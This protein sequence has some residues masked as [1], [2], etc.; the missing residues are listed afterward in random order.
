MK[1]NGTTEKVLILGT[2]P[3]AWKIAEVMGSFTFRY[4]IVGF[5][6]DDYNCG[7]VVP[8]NSAVLL[9]NGGVLPHNGEALPHNG[10]T[11]QGNGDG[12]YFP[13]SAFPIVGPID[14]LE[15][16]IKDLR[17]DRIIVPIT[18]DGLLPVQALLNSRIEG[19]VVE[20]GDEVYERLTQKLAI[21]SLPPNL[22]I[23]SKD[24]RKPL[25]QMVLRRATSLAFAAI[26]LLLT[27]PLMAII[28]LAIK[29]ESR[30]PIFFFQEREGLRGQKFSLIKFRTMNPSSTEETGWS[31]EISSRVTRV[32]KWLRKYRLDEFPQFINVL[33]GEMDV[34]GPRPE[35]ACNVKTM[36]KLIP[37]YSLRTMIRPGITGWAQIRH[38]YALSQDDVTEK[39]RHDLYYIKHRSTWLDIWILIKTIKVVLKKQGAQ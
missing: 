16:T 17:P 24:L 28:A 25:F 12:A 13:G 18:E 34:V 29:L 8:R 2:K 9:R 20:D 21:E 5:V 38:G 33:R 27:A 10:E 11:L 19:V 14:R 6:D 37:Y 3:L 30:G 32:G 31:R 39:I 22:L 36:G 4:S 35:M 7:G 26:G 23:F 15:N 1:V